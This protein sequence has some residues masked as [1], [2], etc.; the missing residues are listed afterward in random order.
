M[1][2]TSTYL[3]MSEASYLMQL[4]NECRK[5]NRRIDQGELFEQEEGGMMVRKT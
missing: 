2:I 4:V 1:T 3:W 5:L